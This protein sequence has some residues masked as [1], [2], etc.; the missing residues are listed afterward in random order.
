MFARSRQQAPEINVAEVWAKEDALTVDE[1][2]ARYKT[3]EYY[4][5]DDIE[6]WS[7]Q[8]TTISNET[9]GTF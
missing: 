3:R 6:L 5:L 1:R 2:R 4:T 7:Q 8:G 9:K